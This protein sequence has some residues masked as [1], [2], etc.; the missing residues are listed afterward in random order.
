MEGGGGV[1]PKSDSEMD[2]EVRGEAG[3]SQ[4]RH[5]KGHMRNI[6][7]T[8]SDEEAIVDFVKDHEELYDKTN[9]HFKVKGR[10]QCLWERFISCWKQ[11]ISHSIVDQ[12]VMDQFAQMNTML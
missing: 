6:S 1:W 12:Q 7:L 9:E 5:K 2:T 10:K 3:I 4:F 8:D 11:F